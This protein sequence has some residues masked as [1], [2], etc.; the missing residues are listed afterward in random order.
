MIV[1]LK[2]WFFH[3][4][5]L[6]RF[7]LTDYGLFRVLYD[8]ILMFLCFFCLM[9]FFFLLH[10][11]FRNVSWRV[12]LS[13][14]SIRSGIWYRPIDP[15]IFVETNYIVVLG[16]DH[17]IHHPHSTNKLKSI[18]SKIPKFH[19][20]FINI[21]SITQNAFRQAGHNSSPTFH[22]T[23]PNYWAGHKSLTSCE[24]CHF[25]CLTNCDSQL[26]TRSCQWIGEETKG[27]CTETTS[28]NLPL[29]YIIVCSLWAYKDFLFKHRYSGAIP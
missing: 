15:M 7:N 26:E 5:F 4:E 11:E 28:R 1:G 16:S 29:H 21:A 20:S 13:F 2:F 24:S 17:P 25:S 12:G 22:M 23:N 9:E 27:F 3:L 19:P 14:C 8:N 18:N 6:F 10:A